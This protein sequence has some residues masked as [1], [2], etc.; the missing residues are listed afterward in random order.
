MATQALLKNIMKH[1]SLPKLLLCWAFCLWSDNSLAQVTGSITVGGDLDKFYPTVW[2]DGGWSSNLPSELEI[3]RSET[4]TNGSWRGAVIANFK[5]HANGWGNGA[6]FIDADVMQAGNGY[7]G[8]NINFIG[9]WVDASTSS[10][11]LSII[12]WLRG[13]GTTYFYKSLFA[14]S[15]KVY[16]GTANLLPL[17]TNNQSYNYKTAADY[18]VNS[19]GLSKQGTAFFNDGGLNYFAGNIGIGT[20]DTKSYKL[21]VAGNMIAESIKVNLQSAWP[22]YVFSKNYKIVPLAETEKFIN[23]FGHLPGVPSAKVIEADGLNLGEMDILLMKKIE[24]LTVLLI[25]QGKQITD[26]QT[27]IKVIKN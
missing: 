6:N 1:K 19:R 7:L 15:P 21:A 27:Q 25:E 17:Q 14:N 5:Y 23:K 20:T 8:V 26:L 3:G 24:E 10:N 13:G 16:D 2:Q 22:D 18:Y 4:H 12:I 11:S 9:G